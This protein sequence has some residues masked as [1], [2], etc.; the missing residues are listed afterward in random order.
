MIDFS[1]LASYRENNRTEA[2][3]SFTAVLPAGM[4]A[5]GGGFAVLYDGGSYPQSAT[6]IYRRLTECL[7]GERVKR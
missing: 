4:I 7:R 5:H 1:N 2:S 3:V 6:P